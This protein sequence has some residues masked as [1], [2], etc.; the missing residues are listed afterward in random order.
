MAMMM[1]PVRAHDYEIGVPSCGMFN[2]RDL[3]I[4]GDHFFR[5]RDASLAEYLPDGHHRR[6]GSLILMRDVFG[7]L[8]LAEYRLGRTDVNVCNA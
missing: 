4:S 7:D 5:R 3:W 2:N 6:F 1:V 8:R